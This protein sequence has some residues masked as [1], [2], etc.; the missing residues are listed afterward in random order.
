MSSS[1]IHLIECIR[2]LFFL[3]WIIFHCMYILHFVYPFICLWVLELF[4]SFCSPSFM[5]PRLEDLSFLSLFLTDSPYLFLS[6]VNTHKWN[7]CVVVMLFYFMMFWHLK[8]LP[9][10]GT[11]VPPRADWFLEIIRNNSPTNMTFIY[12]PANPKSMSSTTAFM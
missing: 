8:G 9:G 2:I 3:R 6:C 10:R 1:F 7:K 4:P 5:L 11:N 12:K